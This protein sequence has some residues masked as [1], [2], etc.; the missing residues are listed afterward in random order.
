MGSVGEWVTQENM[1]RFGLGIKPAEEVKATCA[2]ADYS[3]QNVLLQMGITPLTFDGFAVRSVK[4]WGG[5]A[6]KPIYA[7][8][9]VLLGGRDRELRHAEKQRDK[10]RQM[11]DPFNEDYACRAWYQRSKAGC[12]GPSDLPR[13]KAGLG[14]ANPNANNYKHK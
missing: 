14:R 7:E 13:M 1:H 3:V 4:L 6:W 12:K 8:D 10:E 5:R 2:T 9:E 11:H